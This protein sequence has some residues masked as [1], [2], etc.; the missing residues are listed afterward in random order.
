MPLLGNASAGQRLC[1][2][3]PLLYH[4]YLYYIP[5]R[6]LSCL[7]PPP[8][9]L[10]ESYPRPPYWRAPLS[11]STPALTARF[12]DPLSGGPSPYLGF[13]GTLTAP[14]TLASK[15]PPVP[16]KLIEKIKAL[17]YVDMKDL[18]PNNMAAAEQFSPGGAAPTNT[19]PDRK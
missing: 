9:P 14:F 5:P 15:F 18:L 1:W 8:L 3:T 10:L 13:P 6:A 11:T 7:R 19:H 17:K 12:L 16:S 2:A 4:S